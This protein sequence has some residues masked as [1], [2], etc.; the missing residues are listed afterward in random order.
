[1]TTLRDENGL[2]DQI[3]TV[4]SDWIVPG[5]PPAV[6]AQNVIDDLGLEVG[7]TVKTYP[8]PGAS[9][10]EGATVSLG[11]DGEWNVELDGIDVSAAYTEWID[12]LPR[13]SRI[14]GPY[15]AEER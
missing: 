9:D 4:I 8:A 13:Q 11:E 12:S 3:E 15:E 1:M 7:T 2:R 14:I 5:I 10:F 6:I